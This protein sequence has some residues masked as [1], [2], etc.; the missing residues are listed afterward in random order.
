MDISGCGGITAVAVRHLTSLCG[1]FLRFV[2]ISFTNIDS[3]AL[4][5]L[6]GFPAVID[7]VLNRNHEFEKESGLKEYLSDLKEIAAVYK[8]PVA[9]NGK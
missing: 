8:I 4:F 6:A 9:N 3:S 5:S 2:S 7:F 1:P